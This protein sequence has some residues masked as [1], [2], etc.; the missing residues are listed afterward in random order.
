MMSGKTRKGRLRD[1]VTLG[2]WFGDE[3]PV[4]ILMIDDNPD[5]LEILRLLLKVNGH[6]P[7]MALGGKEGLDIAR[8]ELPD[9]ILLDLM[10]PDIDGFGVLRQL[11]LDTSTQEIPVI[12]VTAVNGHEFIDKAMSLGAEGYIT[13]PYARNQL[14]SLI[15]E[16]CST[17]AVPA[18]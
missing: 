18:K 3:L 13:K 6:R 10:M 14:M 1:R 7:I 15:N 4:N 8:K 16:A 12:F 11:K 17:A 2:T 9:V 5:M